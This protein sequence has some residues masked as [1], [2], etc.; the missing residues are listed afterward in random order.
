MV[1]IIYLHLK[2]YKNPNRSDAAN[3]FLIVRFCGN[4]SREDPSAIIAA[5]SQQRGRVTDLRWFRQFREKNLIV[6]HRS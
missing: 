5:A 2:A 1:K 6:S 4:Q 3:Y